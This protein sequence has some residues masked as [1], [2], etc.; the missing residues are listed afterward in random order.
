MN[1]S[2]CILMGNFSQTNLLMKSAFFLFKVVGVVPRIFVCAT[3]QKVQYLACHLHRI[4]KYVNM[5]VIGINM[6]TYKL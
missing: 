2:M 1:Q 3:P 5:R 6:T 4:I